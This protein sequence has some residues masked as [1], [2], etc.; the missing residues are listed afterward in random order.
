M[1]ESRIREFIAA[2]ERE[3]SAETLRTFKGASPFRL[4]L[5]PER[6]VAGGNRRADSLSTPSA[7]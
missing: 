2:E 5:G 4:V 1:L 7:A 6:F 3:R